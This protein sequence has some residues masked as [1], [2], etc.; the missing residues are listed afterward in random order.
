MSRN[1]SQLAL[2][3]QV[4]LRVR[5]QLKNVLSNKSEAV[6]LVKSL[7]SRVKLPDAEPHHVVAVQACTLE[8][9]I[10]QAL[11][12]TFSEIFLMRVEPIELDGPR[13]G[14]ARLNVIDDQL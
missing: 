3:Q 2:H 5:T 7:C 9:L 14:H 1:A 6:F 13:C 10:H 8:T 11:A 4:G 12:D